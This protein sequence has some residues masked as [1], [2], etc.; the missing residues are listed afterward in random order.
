MWGA[1][2]TELV[3]PSPFPIY[4]SPLVNN[5]LHIPTLVILT[6]YSCNMVIM[7]LHVLPMSILN[8][9]K[10][11][12]RAGSLTFKR[13]YEFW[14]VPVSYVVSYIPHSLYVY[15]IYRGAQLLLCLSSEISEII[16]P[17]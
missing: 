7:V 2:F 4:T 17:N 15:T 14:I 1:R 3:D 10:M 8:S 9:H 5:T 16:T 12:T 13:L 6:L 11:R